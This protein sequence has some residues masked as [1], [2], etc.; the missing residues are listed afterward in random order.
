MGYSADEACDVGSDTGSP[1]SPDYGPTGN[2]FT[3]E[4]EWVQFDIGEDSHD[5][6]ITAGG[7]VQSGDGAPIA[8]AYPARAMGWT[9]GQ[10][11]EAHKCCAGTSLKNAVGQAGA[12]RT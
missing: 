7:A 2:R 8:P 6:L 5:H 1:A 3:G 12:G 4:I 9:A 10:Q 11:V